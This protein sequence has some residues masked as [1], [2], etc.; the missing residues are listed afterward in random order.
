M[1]IETRPNPQ[2]EPSLI[3]GFIEEVKNKRIDINKY[4]CKIIHNGYEPR[5]LTENQITEILSWAWTM[6]ERY[7][8]TARIVLSWFGEL[9]E[10]A[11]KVLSPYPTVNPVYSANDDENEALRRKQQML[12]DWK[13]CSARKRDKC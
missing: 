10:G 8:G 1:T 7:K 11:K 6:Q 5:P 13:N 2:I 12:K 4:P 9:T 3:T